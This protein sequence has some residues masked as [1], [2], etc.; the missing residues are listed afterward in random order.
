MPTKV[1]E[2]TPVTEA[3][4]ADSRC[5]ICF[6]ANLKKRLREDQLWGLCPTNRKHSHG[7]RPNPK[8]QE[9]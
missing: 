6:P 3:K 1:K 4:G 5:V 7:A 9:T 2:L 8:T